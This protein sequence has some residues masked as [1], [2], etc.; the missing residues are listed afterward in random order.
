MLSN[1]LST[2]A[3]YN[4]MSC[5]VLTIDGPHRHTDI[6]KDPQP[7]SHYKHRNT[8]PPFSS[9]YT[10]FFEEVK[11]KRDFEK[12]SVMVDAWVSELVKLGEKVRARK[13]FL[14]KR[15]T[16]VDQENEASLP[17]EKD[18]SLVLMKSAKEAKK[19]STMSETTIFLI[20]DRFAP[21]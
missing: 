7:L 15:R 20:M 6:F 5:C 12:M 1:I 16:D 8:S 10:L 19:D 14:L 11:F 18:H 21:M 13:P 4:S 2:Y 3:S 17:K 9:F